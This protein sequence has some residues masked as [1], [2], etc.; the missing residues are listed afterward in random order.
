[1]T[2]P[3]IA[4]EKLKVEV[5]GK[6]I[7][8]SVDLTMDPGEVHILFGPN[9][10]GK[11]TLVGA[12]MGLPAY[13]IKAGKIYF[14]GTDITDLPVEER[15]QMGVGMA[16]Q[17]PPVIRGLKLGKLL[18]ELS[19][20]GDDIEQMARDLNMDQFL[21]RDLNLGFSG[22]ESKR[23]EILMLLAQKPRL[24]FLDEPESGVDLE[25][26]QLLG[27]MIGRILGRDERPG[28]PHDRTDRSALIIS[29]TGNILD[30][31]HAD[32]GHVLFGGRMLC[33]ANPLDI[34]DTVKDNGYMRCADCLRD[35]GKGVIVY[36]NEGKSDDDATNRH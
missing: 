20:N 4:V 2:T 10:S 34:L 27:K 26:V 35:R 18:R 7:L 16:F 12:I 28:H 14:N 6:E 8:H 21:D 25:N 3:L 22:G 30:Y 19:G 17:R 11:T 29:H 24:V 5:A 32:K 1:M 31:L 13:L 33:G 9:G 36:K 15:A 23:A